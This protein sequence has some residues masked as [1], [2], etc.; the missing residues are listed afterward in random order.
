MLSAATLDFPVVLVD[1][2]DLP[3]TASEAD[4]VDAHDGVSA[5]YD[6]ATGGQLDL[7]L[8]IRA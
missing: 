3:F 6:A 1:F 2:S 4:L 7:G 5:F 8:Q